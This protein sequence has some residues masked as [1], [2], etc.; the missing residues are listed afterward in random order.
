[1]RIKSY[2]A[3][4]TRSVKALET[5]VDSPILVVRMAVREEG[6]PPMETLNLPGETDRSP[7]ATL[8]RRG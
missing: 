7:E 8:S 2:W 1:M 3:V 6:E 5:R 4:L